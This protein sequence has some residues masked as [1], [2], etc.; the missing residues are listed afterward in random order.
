MSEPKRSLGRRSLSA[1][2]VDALRAQ[3]EAG[4]YAPRDKLPTEPALIEKFGVSRTVVREAIAALRADG[5]V[6]SRQGSGVFVT[7]PQQGDTGL[8]LFTGETD[9]ISDIIEELELRIGIEVEAAGLA[10]ARSS[11]AQEAEIQSQ[12]ERFSRLVA[13]GRPTDEADFH[14]HMAIATAT[15]NARFR[16]FL[17]HVGRRMIPRVKFRT[18]MGGVDPLP[19]RDAPIL[20]E[21]RDIAESIMARDPDRAREAMRRHLVTGIKRYRSLTSWGQGLKK[22]DAG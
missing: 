2:V 16:T 6:E 3:I 13:E 17:E 22:D 1:G 15:N 14:F 11:P 7:G 12:V 20:E 5:L 8:R 19:S 21:H 10:A 4:Y 9:K 18:V